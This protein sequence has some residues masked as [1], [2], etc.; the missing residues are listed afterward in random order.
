MGSIERELTDF[1]KSR[2]SVAGKPAST[3]SSRRAT[4]T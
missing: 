4:P 3:G 2:D 1:A